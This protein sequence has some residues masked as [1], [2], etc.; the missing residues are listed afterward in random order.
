MCKWQLDIHN[1]NQFIAELKRMSQAAA[2]SDVFES[3]AELNSRWNKLT[4]DADKREV[5]SVSLETF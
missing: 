3:A 1:L 5:S 4:L 2:G